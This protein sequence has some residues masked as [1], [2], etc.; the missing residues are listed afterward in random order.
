MTEL[1]LTRSISSL[2]LLAK[3]SE[4]RGSHSLPGFITGGML[5][6]FSNLRAH[7]ST[8]H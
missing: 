4:K 7:D 8:R 6:L 2:K 1:T 3:E 5:F